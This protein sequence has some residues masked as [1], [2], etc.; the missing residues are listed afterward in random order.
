MVYSYYEAGRLI[1][2]Q[3]QEGEARAAYGVKTINRR[4]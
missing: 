1:V 2:E 4:S 3:E